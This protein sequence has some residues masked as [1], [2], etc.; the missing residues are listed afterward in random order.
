M[1]N[2]IKMVKYLLEHGADPTIK[3]KKGETALS[4]AQQ[5]GFNEIIK[6]LKQYPKK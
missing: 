6:L 3:T 1:A 4:L 2:N 5:E